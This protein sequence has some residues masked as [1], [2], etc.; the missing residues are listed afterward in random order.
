MQTCGYHFVQPLPR[1]IRSS[2][3]WVLFALFVFAAYIKRQHTKPSYLLNHQYAIIYTAA[4]HPTAFPQV[5]GALHSF[6][7]PGSN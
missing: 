5:P 1:D 6:E 4:T 7:P 3:K 2:S